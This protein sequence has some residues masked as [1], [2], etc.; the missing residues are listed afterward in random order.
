[1]ID[2]SLKIKLEKDKICTGILLYILT[3]KGYSGIYRTLENSLPSISE[4]WNVD[5]QLIVMN[6]AK[7][8]D[9]NKEML[10]KVKGKKVFVNMQNATNKSFEI[11][12]SEKQWP[13]LA[14]LCEKD[15]K[16]A[17]FATGAVGE[18]ASILNLLKMSG[19]VEFQEGEKEEGGRPLPEDFEIEVR[20]FLTNVMGPFGELI[21][22]EVKENLGIEKLTTDNCFSFVEELRSKMDKDCVYKGRTCQ[23]VIEAIL[24]KYL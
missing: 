11:T 7:E 16:S 24:K 19:L 20:E 23:E 8:Y 12:I 9:E 21:V 4:K 1:M 6:L 3:E 10:E 15:L 5:M 22:Y 13:V 14:S 17:M 2:T 18:N